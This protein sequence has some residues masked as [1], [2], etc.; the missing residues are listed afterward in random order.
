MKK[1]TMFALE[2]AD[3]NLPISYRWFR[4]VAEVPW[5]IEMYKNVQSCSIQRYLH[6]EKRSNNSRLESTCTSG[7][8]HGTRYTLDHDGQKEAKSYEKQA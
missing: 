8:I 5:A 4:F 2:E 3:T 1:N 7:T 6:E